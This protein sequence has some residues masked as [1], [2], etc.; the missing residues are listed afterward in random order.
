MTD[1]NYNGWT[2]YETWCVNLWLSNDEGTYNEVNDLLLQEQSVHEAETALSD[3]VEGLAESTCEGSISGASFVVDLLGSALANVNWT[4]I[5]ESWISG[6]DDWRIDDHEI[7]GL[8]VHL[9]SL[10][11]GERYCGS[12]NEADEDTADY[13]RSTCD[14]CDAEHDADDAE[15]MVAK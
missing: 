5:V 7:L 14:D 10:K 2:N 1:K 9:T 15:G 4:E 11:T 13:A 6:L 3:F 12:D 8:T